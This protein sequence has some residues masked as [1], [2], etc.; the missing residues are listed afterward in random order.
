MMDA[1]RNNFR[2]RRGFSFVEVLF[3]VMILGVGFI[4][5]AAMFPVAIQQTQLTVD[6][7]SA[8]RVGQNALNYLKAT[9]L[10]A[11]YPATTDKLTDATNTGQRGIVMGLREKRTAAPPTMTTITPTMT[12]NA[13]AKTRGNLIDSA[14]GRYAWV[15]AY[16]RNKAWNGVADAPS[17]T[18]KVF[19]FTVGCRNRS[20]Y[21]TPDDVLRYPTDADN[22]LQATLEPLALSNVK[23][24]SD[25]TVVFP[26]TQLIG[27]GSYI[28]VSDDPGTLAANGQVFRIGNS[29]SADTWQLEPGK[30]LSAAGVQPTLGTATIT[31]LTVGRGVPD[32]FA[33][34]ATPEGAVQDIS[35][36]TE[37]ITPK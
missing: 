9:A 11:D 35:V 17:T 18:M 10:S 19:L 22:D 20:Q 23:F 29:V 26:A 1:R 14:D 6:E 3:A 13:Y 33:P 7:T 27:P 4:M 21:K 30:D 34:S 8:A 28:V 37:T 36:I 31:V 15:L 25:N 24:N 2:P 32:P 5:I 12:A 16:Q